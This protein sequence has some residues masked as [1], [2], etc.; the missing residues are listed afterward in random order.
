M[1]KRRWAIALIGSIFV[2]IG[3]LIGFVY[4]MHFRESSEPVYM[5]VSL[6]ELLDPVE[7]EAFRQA[8]KEALPLLG[9]I[10]S[11]P[12]ATN[13]ISSISNGSGA[14]DGLNVGPAS[15]SGDSGVSQ[16]KAGS[17]AASSQ[18]TSSGAGGGA[19]NGG[20]KSGISRGPRVVSRSEPDYPET[21][22][23]NGWQG[24]V[25]LQILVSRQGSVEDVKLVAGSGYGELDEAAVQNIRT[26]RF[27]P[28]LQN[29]EATDAWVTVPV[30]F[31]LR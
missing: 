8:E 2:N 9:A 10:H 5:E 18:T 17:G 28:A 26:W 24:T 29:G 13:S 19:Q 12:A 27:I 15:M 14:A 23:E 11:E 30:S 22:R 3:V 16:G 1:P 20:V 7:T 4:G 6:Q 25:R 21:A 31:S